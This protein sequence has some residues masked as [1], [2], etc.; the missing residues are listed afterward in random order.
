MYQ[1]FLDYLLEQQ[2]YS[3]N[4][5]KNYEYDLQRLDGFFSNHHSDFKKVNKQDCR[6]YISSRFDQKCTAKTISRE[7]STFRHFWGF[8]QRQQ[9]VVQNPWKQI[10]LPKIEKKLPVIIST[11]KMIRFLDGIDSSTPVG[12]RNRAICECLYGLGLRVSEL[13]GLLLDQIYV[14]KGECRVIGKGQKERIAVFG[15]ITQSI[16]KRYLIDSRPLWTVKESKT[17]FV[18]PKGKPLTERTV[19]RIVKKCS[20]EQGIVPALTPHVLRHCYASD[21]YKGGADISVIKELLGHDHLATTEIYTHVA[22]E[23]LKE[24]MQQAHPRN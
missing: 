3:N 6:L 17:L 8:L 18:G 10:R 19:Q 4:T 12:L 1:R 13:C 20:L 11:K 24:T 21:L 23:E 9:L 2:Q 5:V 7:I 16:I 14:E 15:E 22:N